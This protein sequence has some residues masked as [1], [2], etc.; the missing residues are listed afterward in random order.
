MKSIR[1]FCLCPAWG[2]LTLLLL[3][4]TATAQ[5]PITYQ[6]Q[7]KQAGTPFTGTPDLEFRLYNSLVGGNQV[8]ATITRPDWPVA[9][10]LFQVELDFG[11]GAFGPDPRWLEIVVDGSVL[12]P[13]QRVQAAPM[14][15]FALDGNEGPPG[16]PGPAG[17]QGPPGDSH[18]QI[19]DGGP[20]AGQVTYYDDGWVGI[21]VVDPQVWLDVIGLVRSRALAH[22]DPRPRT[23]RVDQDGDLITEMQTRYLSI[24]PAT[25]VVDGD[26]TEVLRRAEAFSPGTIGIAYAPVHLP[27]RAEVTDFVAWVLNPLTALFN[28]EIRLTRCPMGAPSSDQCDVMAL[29]DDDTPSSNIQVEFD[30]AIEFAEIDNRNYSYFVRFSCPGFITGMPVYICDVEQRLH[31]LRIRYRTE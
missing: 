15:M 3:T 12:S 22:S 6:G 19:A 25:F 18:W 27:H 7:L 13:R 5:Q 23:V 28:P 9:D 1:F 20:F 30:G 29:I 16:P 11:A 21:G 10:G 24:P 8:G 26:E 2:A 31:G 14:A 17:P 4:A